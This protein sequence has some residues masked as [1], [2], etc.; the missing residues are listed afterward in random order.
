MAGNPNYGTIGLLS[1]T[2]E[3]FMPRFEQQIFKKKVL[4]WILQ[5][6]G[7]IQN[8]DGGTKIVQ[9]LIYEEAANVGSYADYDTFATDPNDGISA[10]EFPWKQYYGLL[11]ISGI[12][13]KMNRGSSR[14]LNLL[15]GRLEQLE[16]TMAGNINKQLFDDGSG[17][18]GKDF[19]GLAALISQTDP[20]WGDLGGIDRSANT[21]WVPA[22]KNHSAAGATGLIANMR[23]VYNSASEGNDHPNISITTQTLFELYEDQLVSNIRY[24]DTKTGDAGFENLMFKGMPI[25]FDSD[26][27]TASGTVAEADNPMWMLNTQY[28]QLKK[29][30]DVWFTPSDEMLQPVNQDAFYKHI[31]CY[32][33]FTVSNV[34]RQG[35]L[36]NVL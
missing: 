5:S 11:H 4:L 12:E 36:Y 1:T 28:L 24:T 13:L 18:S 9:P 16:L 32:G 7:R 35:V 23:N 20:S 15:K 3:K 21:W 22:F 10:A 31:L 25:T 17:N 6:T 34:S 2:T 30:A 8:E 26:A 14:V 33:N 27:D 19:Y 29:L